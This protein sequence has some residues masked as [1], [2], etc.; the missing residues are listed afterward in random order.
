MIEAQI[1][2]SEAFLY[3]LIGNIVPLDMFLPEFDG[4]FG[5]AVGRGL[6]LAGAG[7]A[8]HAV[9]REGGINRAGLA[10]RVCIIQMIVSKAAV[11]KD[12]LLDQTLPADLR[13]KIDVF[14]GATGSS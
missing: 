8:L 2:R 14:L 10:V 12:G 4:A 6:N 7:A 13:H 3:A 11:E 1:L 9:E 5:D